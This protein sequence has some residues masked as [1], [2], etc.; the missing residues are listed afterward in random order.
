[1]R[2]LENG[3]PYI[4]PFL[5]GK[6]IIH[7]IPKGRHSYMLQDLFSGPLPKQVLISFVSHESFNGTLKTNPFIFENLKINM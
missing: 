1:M 3:D 6:Q 7:T 2:A 5:Q 4:M